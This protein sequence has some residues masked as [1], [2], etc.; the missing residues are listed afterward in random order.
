MFL[1]PSA[2][3]DFCR[4]WRPIDVVSDLSKALERARDSSREEVDVRTLR[5]HKIVFTAIGWL[6]L[7]VPRF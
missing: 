3:L 2:Y 5:A 4:L 1:C 6:T 7:Q